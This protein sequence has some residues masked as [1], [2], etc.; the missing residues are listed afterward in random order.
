MNVAL[1]DRLALTVPQTAALVGLS[2]ASIRRLI[3]DGVLARVAHTDRVLIARA[4]LDRWLSE[5]SAA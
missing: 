1:N 2:T 4:E 3:A 5:R